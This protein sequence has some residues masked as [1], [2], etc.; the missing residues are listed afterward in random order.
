MS[1][2]RTLLHELADELADHLEA[3]VER[4]RYQEQ[5]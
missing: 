5:S 2:L 3:G 1:K 4:A